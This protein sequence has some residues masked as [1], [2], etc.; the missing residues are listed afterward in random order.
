MRHG[1]CR[2]GPGGRGDAARLQRELD[3]LQATTVALSAPLDTDALLALIVERAATLVGGAHG[4]VYVRSDDGTRMVE[5]IAQGPLSPW[6]GSEITPDEGNAGLVWRTGKAQ[7]DNDYRANTQRRDIGEATPAAVLG[8]PLRVR[9][10]VAGVLGLARIEPGATFSLEDQRLVERFAQIASLAIERVSLHA[11]LQRE[12]EQRRSTEEELLHTVARLTRSELALKQSHEEM[13]RRLASAAEQ[14][15]GATGRHIEQMSATCELVARRLG[16]DDAF[17]ENLRLASPLHDIGKIAVGDDLLLK[18]G[19]LDE[20]ERKAMEQHAEIGH[21]MLC[22]AG[23]ELLDLAASIALTHH[24]RYDGTGYP[25]GLHGEDIPLEGRIA[26]VADVFDALTSDRAYR[27]AFPVEQAL[28]MMRDGSGTHFDP[29]VLDAFLD[30]HPELDVPDAP[31][32]RVRLPGHHDPAPAAPSGVVSE[33]ALAR[34]VED[35]IDALPEA[36]SAREAIDEALKRLCHAAGTGV[37]ASVYTLDHDR[38]WCLAQNGYSQVRDG[39]TLHQ[40]VMGRALR[41]ETVVFLP[42][43]RVDDTFIGAQAGI[44]SELALP[45]VGR[46]A[47]AL[48]NVETVGPRLPDGAVASLTPLGNALL[49]VIDALDPPLKLDLA[50]LARLAVYASS[51]RSVAELSELATRTLGRLLDLEAAQL[52][53]GGAASDAP[54]SFWRRPE[55]ALQPIPGETIAAVT[56][57]SSLGEYT[58]SVLDGV[59]IELA[60]P[61]E[62]GRFLLWLPLRIRGV[63]LG[64]LVGRSNTPIALGHE[65]AEAATLFAQQI[66]AL[67]DV[68]LALR[69]EQRAAVTDSLTGLLN[70]RGFDERLREEIAR[71]ER[72]GRPFAVVLTDCDDLKRINDRFG[73]ERGDAVLQAI[74]RLLRNGKRLPD[75]AGRVGG[76][77][78]GLILPESGADAVAVVTE[79]LRVAVHDIRLEG[80]G[81]TASFGIAV[82]PDNGRTSAALLRAADRALYEAKH[83]G[84]DRLAGT[85]SGA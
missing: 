82:Y 1:T 8:A 76:D 49:E 33:E 38:I 21:Q 29:V 31:E 23:S 34:A 85:V 39:F 46:N 54:S 52:T 30:I 69:R 83:G 14:R 68:A 75:I 45:L 19:P 32:P 72:S 4:Y 3:A 25:R 20:A 51:L 81:M 24:E 9:G 56:A 42:D 65:Q 57:G 67:L 60:G 84:K 18:P 53:L 73:H 22:D 7:I 77:E 47:R 11:D 58:W 37:L 41:T 40:G 13:V 64:T 63:L 6:A 70:R 15:D 26:A 2:D 48:L 44:T 50:T 71:A 28:A 16:L 17:C 66:A 55:S 27:P 12:L 79:R 78:F 36:S 35:A 59:D 43:V 74:A 5:R 61:E 62:R 10:E 80:E